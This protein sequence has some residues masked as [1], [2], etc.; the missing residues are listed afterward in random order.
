MFDDVW[1]IS[2]SRRGRP[3]KLG[4]FNGIGFSDELQ[5]GRRERPVLRGSPTRTASPPRSGGWGLAVV[6]VTFLTW[7]LG[8][9]FALTMPQPRYRKRW[10]P[11][12]EARMIG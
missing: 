11:L 6:I 9:I 5:P 12:R 4:T 3:R 10:G 1:P 7:L 2:A 8:S